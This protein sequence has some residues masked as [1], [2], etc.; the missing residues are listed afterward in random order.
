V[1]VRIQFAQGP[2][3]TRKTGKNR[4]LAYTLGALMKPA[5]LTCYVLGVWRLGADLKLTSEFVFDGVY[6]HWQVWIGIGA[7]LH[8]VSFIL[9]RYGSGGA[10]RLPS[11][12]LIRASSAAGEAASAPHAK[13][14]AG[15]R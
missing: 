5:V 1:I 4:P 6:S 3:V 9:H 14:A 8:I 2:Q 12:F 7:A 15:S 11:I 13:R 10:L